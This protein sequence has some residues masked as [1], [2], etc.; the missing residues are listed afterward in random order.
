[1]QPPPVNLK[2]RIAALQQR[3][4]GS[5]GSA[6]QRSL[7]PSPQPIS[8]LAGLS[9]PT[10]T[11]PTSPATGNTQ[12]PAT[13]ALREKIARFEKK[14]G[15]PVP[16]GSFGLGAPP[17]SDAH[18]PRRQNELYGNRI[19]QP[20]RVVSSGSGI[21]QRRR[22]LTTTP[23]TGVGS[24]TT[25]ITNGSGVPAAAPDKRRSVSLSNV[26]VTPAHLTVVDYDD[27]EDHNNNNTPLT[28]PVF[29]S[30]SPESPLNATL[31]NVIPNNPPLTTMT[32]STFHFIPHC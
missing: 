15:I 1:M 21:P 23:T 14:G 32:P 22:D 8:S 27:D 7:S 2:E 26:N 9:S 31:G 29:P 11:S 6:T 19:P 24:A 25:S 16:R 5:N 12:I 20:L 30:S 4:N 3:S 13:S 17:P 18:G 28:S 10:T